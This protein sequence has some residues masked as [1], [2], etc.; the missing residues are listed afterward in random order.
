MIEKITGLAGMKRL[1]VLSVGRN[2]IKSFSGLVS[3]LIS[4]ENHQKL[5]NIL[6]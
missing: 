1:K 3:I 5:A 6:F 2:Y 4:I